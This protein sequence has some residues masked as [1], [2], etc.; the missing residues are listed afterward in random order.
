[1]R[2]GCAGPALSNLMWEVLRKIQIEASAQGQQ[3]LLG[4]PAA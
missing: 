4:L 2:P 3:F 1:V